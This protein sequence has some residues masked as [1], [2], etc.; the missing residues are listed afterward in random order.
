VSSQYFR[1]TARSAERPRSHLLERLLA[2]AESQAPV[3]DWRADAFR[4]IAP[5]ADSAQGVGAAVLCADR[6]PLVAGAT[7]F[8]WVCVATP[9][10]Y[11]AEMSNVRLPLDGMLALSMASAATLAADFNRVWQGSGISLRAARS[12]QLLCT[13]D[14]PLTVST[15]DP[16]DVLGLH[17]EEF[18]PTGADSRHLRQLISETEMWLFEH[19]ANQSRQE[20]GLPA[21][22]GLWFWGGA[23]PLSVLPEVQ[24]WAAGDDLFFNAVGRPRDEQFASGVIAAGSGPGGGEW[25]QAESWLEAAAE[26]LRAG[27]IARLQISAEDRCFTVTARGL[28]R[29]WRRRKPWWE[30]FG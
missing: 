8:A 4:V 26:Q 28:K 17:I 5:Q 25:H 24:G 21:V 12:A 9:V 6:G 15:R 30:W 19:P 10:H 13:F 22:N 1:F 18:L 29:F 20:L 16:Q 3:S 7:D 14:R 11:T 23:T 27:R 2:R